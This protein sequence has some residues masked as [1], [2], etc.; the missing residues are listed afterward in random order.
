MQGFTK[1]KKPEG[2]Q[3]FQGTSKYQ[4]ILAPSF[5]KERKFFIK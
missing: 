3:R 4:E 1:G 5:Q 2:Q